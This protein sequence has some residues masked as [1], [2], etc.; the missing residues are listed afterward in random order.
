MAVGAPPSGVPPDVSASNDSGA[1]QAGVLPS[2]SVGRT[3]GVT[4]SGV[5]QASLP[6]MTMELQS[7]VPSRVPAGLAVGA[8]PSGVPPGV[9]AS[10]AFEAPR[11][12]VFQYPWRHGYWSTSF[13]SHKPV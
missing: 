7:G 3:V 11:P 1:A 13:R 8:T 12:G 4:P 9:S 5:L 10:N 2:F 6:V